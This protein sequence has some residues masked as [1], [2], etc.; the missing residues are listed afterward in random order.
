METINTLIKYCSFIFMII[1]VSIY[2]KD[3]IEKYFV[4]KQF[5]NDVVNEFNKVNKRLDELDSKYS[6]IS[7][8]NKYT[9]N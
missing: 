1:I 6:K 7:L 4:S 9:I 2:V 3:I 5:K 8:K